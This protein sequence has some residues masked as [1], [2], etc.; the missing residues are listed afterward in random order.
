MVDSLSP[1]Y[2]QLGVNWLPLIH[3]IYLPIVIFEAQYRSGLI[4]SLISVCA[5][6][7]SGYLAYKISYR[8]TGSI[9][10]GVFAAVVLLANPNLQYLQSCP[11]T[12]PLYL[13][14][15][16]LATNSL[17]CWREDGC[18]VLPWH[19]AI[20]TSLG[21]MCRLRRLVFVLRRPVA[22]CVRFLDAAYIPAQDPADRGA[23]F[24]RLWGCL[25]S[26][27]FGYIFL[28]L[29][30]IFSTGRA[31]KSKS[32]CYL[33]APFSFSDLPPGELS[34]MA[35]ILPLL[36]AAAGLLLFLVQRREFKRRVP[37]LLLWLP[38]TD[39]YLRSTGD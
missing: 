22:P 10:G 13:A 6:A 12:E 20:W 8:L 37:L 16:L 31:G 38:F 21:A 36:V 2:S 25:H 5:F 4:P 15:L 34:Q 17:I 18:T 35:A 26:P 7:L 14:L 29:G 3:L 9:T 30:I 39:Q 24:W 32:V 27:H 19:A 11:L 1:G 28:S 33:P 23:F